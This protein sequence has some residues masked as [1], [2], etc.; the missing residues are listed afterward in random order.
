MCVLAVCRFWGWIKGFE[1]IGGF[2]RRLP[3]KSQPPP[4][5]TAQRA[6]RS[7]AMKAFTV[8]DT[9]SGLRDSGSAVETTCGVV[10][11]GGGEGGLRG[12]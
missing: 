7:R 11:V 2:E 4:R 5:S 6:C 3:S 12:G 9:C 1:R 8:T 10:V